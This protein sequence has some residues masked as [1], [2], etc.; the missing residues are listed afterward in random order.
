MSILPKCQIRIKTWKKLSVF[1]LLGLLLSWVVSCST[2]NVSNGAPQ[3][4]SD[5]SIEFWTMQLQPEFT[6]YFKEL[7]GNFEL[8]N[9]G[10]KIKWV[11]VPWSAMQSKILTAVSAKTAPDVVNLNP[12]FA[13]QLAGRN[14][15]L[16]LDAKVPDE[17]R[18]TYLPNI[19][20]AS[21]LNGKSFGI[22]WYLTTQLTIYNTNLLKQAGI[23]KP[24]T[25][26]VELAQQ[27]AQIKQ[28]TGKYALF[29]TFVPEDSGEVL[30]S[31]VQMGVSLLDTQGQAAFNTPEGKAVFQYWVNLYKNGLLPREALTQG[32]RHAIELYQAGETALLF[33]G[34]EFLK[35][36]AKNAPII[37]QSSGT[38]PQITGETGKKNVSVM[39]LVIPRN[40]DQPDAALK[41][42]LFVTNNQNQLAFAKAAEVLPS[43]ILALSDSYFKTVPAN[44]S[45]VEKARVISADELKQAEVLI[46]AMKNIKELQ[47]AIYENLQAAML[48]E[49][50]VEQAVADA[51]QQWNLAKAN[52]G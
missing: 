15:W 43:T 33:S 13:S 31:F 20:K 49:K 8:E 52:A 28:K 37:A 6:D 44:T 40:T 2:S 41:F 1:A 5:V 3:T 47:K 19:W 48:D 39:N 27:A 16:T 10:I 50:T 11:D 38:A 30:Q 7:I 22:P 24:P 29:I 9:P 46:P 21:T 35:T 14:A 32:H 25:N 34:G 18:S 12:D 45:S 42:A 23:S 17:V 26:Y 4:T 51:A 36:I